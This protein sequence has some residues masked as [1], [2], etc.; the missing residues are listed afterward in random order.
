M[1][2]TGDTRPRTGQLGGARPRRCVHVDGTEC[3]RG[4]LMPFMPG[5]LGQVLVQRAAKRHVEYLQPAADGK[6]GNVT[7]QRGPGQR[8]LPLVAQDARP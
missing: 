1:V 2:V 5:H 7:L 3:A 4:R 8:E 6:Q